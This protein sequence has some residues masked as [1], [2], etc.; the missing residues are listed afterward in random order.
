MGNAGL[1]APDDLSYNRS[2]NEANKL[3]FSFASFADTG[4]GHSPLEWSAA[5]GL[6]HPFSSRGPPCSGFMSRPC[7]IRGPPCSGR[8]PPCTGGKAPDHG[9]STVDH[10]RSRADHGRNTADHGRNTVDHSR[11]TA[12]QTGTRRTT[13]EHG[14]R[15]R[16]EHGGPR[17]EQSAANLSSAETQPKRRMVAQRCFIT[18]AGFRG[19]PNLSMQLIYL[20]IC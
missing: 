3:D 2:R 6:G 1:R 13:A 14:G 19:V 11:N 20:Y 8:G 12:G 15:P 5:F 7:S 4:T 17:P 9:R 16:S 18:N 10:G